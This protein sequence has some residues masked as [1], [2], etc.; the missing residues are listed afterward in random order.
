[1]VRDAY[2]KN[3][4]LDYSITESKDPTTQISLSTV[5]DTSM[6]VTVLL[7]RSDGRPIFVDINDYAI[8]SVESNNT[9]SVSVTVNKNTR[10]SYRYI[11][12]EG[13]EVMHYITVDNILE[14]APYLAW[15]YDTEEYN[16]DENGEK[17]RYGSVT[18]YLTD[19]NFALTDKYTG[20]MPSF[21][22]VPGGDST[23][24]FK[25]EDIAALLGNELIGLD[26][27]IAVSL[28]I[29][30]YEPPTLFEERGE[31]LETP[32]VQILAFSNLNGVYS[33]EKL[34]VRVENAR[35]S[36]ALNNYS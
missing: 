4:R 10:F 31:D 34:S 28:D 17:Y 30:L 20:K 3:I 19:N 5:K 9:S 27:D 33:D 7:S 26:S 32:N 6:P 11:D 1:M 21:T 8:M 13:Y 2:G 12:S 29:K 16:V 25:K 35:N 15:S 36:N 18:V 23:Y 24:I 22:F 14:P